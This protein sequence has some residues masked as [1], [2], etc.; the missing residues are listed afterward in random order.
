MKK[1]IKVAIAIIL[2]LTSICACS[3]KEIGEP[4]SN[5]TINYNDWNE[6]LKAANGT[7]VE[8]N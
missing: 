4:T 3:N 1:I 7:G 8:A 2:V 6:V 5:K